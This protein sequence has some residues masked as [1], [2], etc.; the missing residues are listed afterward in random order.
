MKYKICKIQDGN[1]KINYTV[2]E[3][4]WYGWK[5]INIYH[6]TGLGQGHYEIMSFF[7]F[8]QAKEWV[9]RTI[10]NTNWIKKAKQKRVV[11]CV[12]V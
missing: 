4:K 12:E 8:E 6:Q 1:N 11:E 10:A 5:N 2:Q 9:D 7:T 3:K